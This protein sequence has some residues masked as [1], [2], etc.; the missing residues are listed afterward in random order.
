MSK[1]RGSA[2]F[3]TDARAKARLE[4]RAHEIYLARGGADGLGLDDWLQAEAETGVEA[5]PSVVQA[6]DD[7]KIPR[8]RGGR[9]EVKP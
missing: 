8:A 3:D 2:S 1:P 5:A 6:D 9:A 4:Y 7:P